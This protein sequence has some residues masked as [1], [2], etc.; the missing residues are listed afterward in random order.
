MAEGGEC[1]NKKRTEPTFWAI[2]NIKTNKIASFCVTG[3]YLISSVFSTKK[4]ATRVLR[5]IGI[6]D[7]K[8]VKKQLTIKK[9]KILTV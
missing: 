3:E 2:V 7:S 4:M 6:L 9:I 8:V 5:V 1:M